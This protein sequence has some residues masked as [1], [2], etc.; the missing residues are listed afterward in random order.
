MLKKVYYIYVRYM[1]VKS[2]YN[3]Y[4]VRIVFL[5]QKKDSI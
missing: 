4:N 5:L 2:L 3:V 1:Y